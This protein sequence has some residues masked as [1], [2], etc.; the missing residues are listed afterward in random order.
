MLGNDRDSA[1]SSREERGIHHSMESKPARR[2]SALSKQRLLAYFTLLSAVS[3]LSI[4]LVITRTG[5]S[6]IANPE[7]RVERRL[8]FLQHRGLNHRHYDIPLPKEHAVASETVPTTLASLSH[9]TVHTDNMD[10]H[11]SSIHTSATT[12][13]PTVVTYSTLNSTPHENVT[14]PPQSVSIAPTQKPLKR[15]FEENCLEYLSFSERMEFRKCKAQ[16]QKR[17]SGPLLKSTCRFLPD[18]SRTAVALASS[19]GSGN[20]WLRG[21]LEKATGI[22]TGFCC[23]DVEMR[24]Q[25][26]PG[27]GISSGKVLV[28]KTHI[29]G[30]QWIG[31]KKKLSW[32]GSY[33]SAV[34][35]VR[36]PARA[37]IAER[38]RRATNKLRKILKNNNTS[39]G[40]SL[41]SHT[42]TV[43]EELF[44]MLINNTHTHTHT[45]LRI[46]II[47]TQK[48]AIA[49][50]LTTHPDEWAE[51]SHK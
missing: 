41:N 23:C 5:L 16:V 9:S 10:A 43:S 22:C 45:H 44:S 47:I 42:N 25:G 35:L 51:P 1:H 15:C 27:E 39:S 19:E 11:N 30:P 34:V 33:G 24:Q 21:L 49:I 26:F 32:E 18:E 37:V 6:W 8:G 20:T 36:N 38:N 50:D 13:K 14:R 12:T 7:H 29:I 46:A 40:Q 17:K 48:A 4:I 3:L 31:Q 2:S 28:V